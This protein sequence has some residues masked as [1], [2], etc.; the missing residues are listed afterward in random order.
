METPKEYDLDFKT[1]H[2]TI[3]E[4]ANEKE[5]EA[6][7]VIVDNHMDRVTEFS[8]HLLQLLRELERVSRKLPATM[9]D[10]G[11]LKR[12]CYI[13]YELTSLNDSVHL[14]APG[15]G[16]DSCLYDNYEGKSTTWTL[17]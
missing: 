8:H 15:P 16:M 6:K 7:Q 5:L 13:I 2:S 4:L 3:V 14:M 9:V 17:S 1:N 10:R 11:L 12:R